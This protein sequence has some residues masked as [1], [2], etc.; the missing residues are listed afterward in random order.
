[1]NRWGRSRAL[2]AVLAVG[3]V[4]LAA[5]GGGNVDAARR[6][7]VE[8]R[9][10]EP[11]ELRVSLPSSVGAGLVT[12]HIKNSTVEEHDAQLIRVTGNQ[13]PDEVVRLFR[14]ASASGF[15]V[16]SW[17]R[18]GGGVLDIEPGETATLRQRLNEGDWYLVDLRSLDRGG[19]VPFIVSSGGSA[20]ELPSATSRIRARD[21]SFEPRALRPGTHRVR[22]ENRGREMHEMVAMPLQA[23][24][25][26]DDAKA[27]LA[28]PTGSPTDAPVLTTNRVR[29][30]LLDR[31]EALVTEL[32]FSP[33][34]WILAC[35]LGDRGGGPSHVVRGMVTEVKI[36]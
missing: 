35:L 24:R 2:T 25:T 10:P 28:N 26:L 3:A 4:G 7:D 11:G 15:R 6:F 22:F 32:T 5:C 23:G 9:Q 19:V 17:V 34:T 30:P 27:Y 12:F 36:G 21:F 33:G 1:M 29:L 31:G 14:A 13:G 8:F 20:A 18:G 16:P